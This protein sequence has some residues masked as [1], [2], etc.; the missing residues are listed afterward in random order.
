MKHQLKTVL[1]AGA[2]LILSSSLAVEAS[3]ENIKA[4]LMLKKVSQVLVP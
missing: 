2:A 1:A 3:A 4:G